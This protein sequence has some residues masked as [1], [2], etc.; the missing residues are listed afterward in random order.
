METIRITASEVRRLAK[1]Q[2]PVLERRC[3]GLYEREFFERLLDATLAEVDA[4]AAVVPPLSGDS[5]F[6]FQITAAA[7]M[8]AMER[9][10]EAMGLPRGEA[11]ER[12]RAMG[13]RYYLG[14]PRIAGFFVRWKLFSKGY[15]RSLAA[16][17][18]ASA[19]RAPE[20]G[21]WLFSI[22]AGDGKAKPL[23]MDFGRC[24]IKVLSER[25]GRP[26]LCA[27]MCSFDFAMAKSFGYSMSR[28]GTLGTGKAVCDFVYRRN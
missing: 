21:D 5:P 13:E 25:L 28:T 22:E 4:V 16:Y 24:G 17:A 8:F 15:Q 11:L 6:R 9:G 27:P 23:V 26:D 2:L 12:M 7:A 20:E 19:G 3:A 1:R 14:M 18:Q 10:M